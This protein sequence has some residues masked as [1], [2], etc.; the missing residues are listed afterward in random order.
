[1]YTHRGMERWIRSEVMNTEF[2]YPEPVKVRQ[3]HMHICSPKTSP[4][5]WEMVRKSLNSSA[6]YPATDN[7]EQR[8]CLK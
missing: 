7:S 3:R 5:R 2:R 1:M 8:P 6:S 4:M